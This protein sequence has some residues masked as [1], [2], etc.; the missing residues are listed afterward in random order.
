[1]TR[2]HIA[3]TVTIALLCVAPLLL[4]SCSKPGSF[5]LADADSDGRVSFPE[6]KDFMLEAIYSEADTNV[7]MK[8][9]FE[10]WRALNP[11]ADEKR[12]YA[13]DADNDKVITPAELKAHFERQGTIEDLFEKMDANDDSFL[14]IEEVDAFK[15]KMDE[16]SGSPIQ[17]L[18]RAA[19]AS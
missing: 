8:V 5:Q 4:S 19:E 14:T 2:R 11:D 1:M 13:P 16:Q 17:R 10:E 12:F 7:D 3:K 9:T 15:E 6:F 18:Q